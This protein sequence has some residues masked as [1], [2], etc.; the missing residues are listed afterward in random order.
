MSVL[1]HE[2]LNGMI[3]EYLRSNGMSKTAD[4]IQAEIK[5]NTSTHIDKF[6]NKKNKVYT[7]GV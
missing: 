6:V 4:N 7:K 2:D 5:S 1:E 3:I